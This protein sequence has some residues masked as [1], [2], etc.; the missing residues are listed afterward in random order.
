MIKID[1]AFVNRLGSTSDVSLVQAI[2]DVA[3]SI[4]AVTVAEGIEDPREMALLQDLGIGLGQGFGLTPPVDA[5]T[6]TKLLNDPATNWIGLT[7][8]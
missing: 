7:S 4:D 6:L 8:P 3:M 1:R 5:A 2:Q